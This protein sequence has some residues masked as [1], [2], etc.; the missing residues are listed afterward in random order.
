MVDFFEQQ[1][2]ARGRTRL[3]V[4]LYLVATGVVTALTVPIVAA[5]IA[6]VVASWAGRR[7]RGSTLAH[8]LEGALHPGTGRY[9]TEG[10][11]LLGVAC[12]AT[13]VL[14]FGTSLWKHGTL[15]R[16]GVAVVRGLGGRAINPGTTDFHE[17]RLL[18]VVEEM[19]IAAGT[20]VPPVY[21]L[22]DEAGINAFAAGHTPSDAV[23]GV[24]RGCMRSLTR[25]QLQGVVGHEFSHILNGDMRLNIRLIALLYGILAVTM[26]GR[27]LLEI[28][29][30]GSDDSW[31]SSRRKGNAAFL[32]LGL[33]AM[34]LGCLGALCARIIKAIISRQREY[35]ADASS[36]QFTR[37][38]NGLAGALRVIGGSSRS[39]VLNTAQAEECSHMYFVDGV[40]GLM[41]TMMATHPRIEK[42]IT[43]LDPSWDGS[44]LTPEEAGGLPVGSAGYGVSALVGAQGVARG[45]MAMP[46]V[47]PLATALQVIEQS[48]L[49]P[50][51]VIRR[52]GAARQLLSRLP[53]MLLDAARTPHDAQALVL[54]LAIDGRDEIR[55]KQLEAVRTTLGA[56]MVGLTEELTR[57]VANGPVQARLPLLEI[58]LAALAALSRDQYQQ[59]RAAAEAVV[60]ADGRVDLFEWSMERLLV[61]HMD[62]RHGDARPK[63]TQYHAL[64]GLRGELSLVLSA[65]AYAG[66]RELAAA[67]HAFITGAAHLSAGPMSIAESREIDRKQLAA[68]FT[69]LAAAS[70]PLRRRIVGACACTVGADGQITASEAEL[71]RVVADSLD[72]PLVVTQG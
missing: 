9:G 22:D 64:S 70:A 23:V 69:K 37:N 56:A 57:L 48:G 13:V 16:G 52:M 50:E 10:L 11:L 44:W 27:V 47:V 30:G 58:A 17:R 25:E 29:Y 34:A 55:A 66:H 15:R 19:A 63:V 45:P 4:A 32:G 46:P 31:W 53:R 28:G 33:L 38:P 43:K 20:P 26:L 6:F 2:R 36:V 72:V 71:L 21:V 5:L 3:M 65:L 51:M 35:L 49:T 54:A 67:A 62:R 8:M 60:R 7:E 59:L 12:A 14:I 18:N 1:Q 40:S 41:S 24:T 61:I 39:G 42:R 68:A